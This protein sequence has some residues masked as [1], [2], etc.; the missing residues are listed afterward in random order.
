MM[1][2][3]KYVRHVNITISMYTTI[4]KRRKEHVMTEIRKSRDML[5]IGNISEAGIQIENAL[6]FD[7]YN[8]DLLNNLA[9]IKLKQGDA[10]NSWNLLIKAFQVNPGDAQVVANAFHVSQI[11]NRPDIVI[12]VCELYLRM[13]PH[14]QSIAELLARSQRA[15]QPVIHNQT[16]PPGSPVIPG[17]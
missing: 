4:L 1:S 7:P 8:T 2:I 3:L 13:N 17:L 11:L 15:A 10:K 14:D 16:P 6:R 5:G 12:P 9:F